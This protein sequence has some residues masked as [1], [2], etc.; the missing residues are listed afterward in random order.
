MVV[1][2]RPVVEEPVK[3]A[4]LPPLGIA[5]VVQRQ[6]RVDVVPGRLAPSVALTSVC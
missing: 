2:G 6:F 5:R 3:V 1:Y 4:G